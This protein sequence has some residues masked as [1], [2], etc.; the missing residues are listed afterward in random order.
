[1]AVCNS[2]PIQISA[3]ELING[4]A[5]AGSD[6]KTLK[7]KD[8][9]GYVVRAFIPTPYGRAPLWVI[10]SRSTGAVRRILRETYNILGSRRFLFIEDYVQDTNIIHDVALW[11]SN[12]SITCNSWTQKSWGRKAYIGYICGDGYRLSDEAEDVLLGI[13]ACLLGNVDDI[14]TRICDEA[15]KAFGEC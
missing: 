13:T 12:G 11:G 9:S 5:A 4:C 6:V 7:L 14:T 15:K 8:G 1:M 2:E 3:A 10:Y